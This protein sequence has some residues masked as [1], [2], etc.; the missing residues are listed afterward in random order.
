MG[1]CGIYSRLL[2]LLLCFWIHFLYRL[3]DVLGLQLMVIA[4]NNVF[5]MGSSSIKG[6]L[7]LRLVFYGTR[8]VS[9]GIGFEEW[10]LV[11]MAF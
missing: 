7:D 5:G 8:L 9:Y 2:V 1:K 11:D 10:S 4:T 6:L 3:H